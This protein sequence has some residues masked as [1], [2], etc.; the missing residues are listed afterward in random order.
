MYDGRMGFTLR[1]GSVIACG[2]AVETEFKKWEISKTLVLP[3]SLEKEA[4]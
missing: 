4:S 3:K 1:S 2:F